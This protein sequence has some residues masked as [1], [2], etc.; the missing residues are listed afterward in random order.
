[1]SIIKL[2]NCILKAWLK[3]THN[4]FSL[5]CTISQVTMH[6]IETNAPFFHLW[7]AFSLL[8]DHYQ[9]II[10][11]IQF[12]IDVYHILW[13]SIS[14]FISVSYEYMEWHIKGNQPFRFWVK[15]GLP[16]GHYWDI[17]N[18]DSEWHIRPKGKGNKWMVVMRLWVCHSA[19]AIRERLIQKE[20]GF[21]RVDSTWK[22]GMWGS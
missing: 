11:F 14:F 4:P 20:D 3:N 10:I 15:L 22:C 2:I 13:Y 19:C 7:A 9:F 6:P 1:M 16:I 21:S 8:K 18:I 5:H 17:F 12:C